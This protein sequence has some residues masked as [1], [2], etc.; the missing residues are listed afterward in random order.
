MKNKK[1]GLGI[2][3]DRNDIS[4]IGYWKKGS[5]ADPKDVY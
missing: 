1:H 5:K 2:Y 3:K 4:Y